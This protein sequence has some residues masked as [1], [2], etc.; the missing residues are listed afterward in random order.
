MRCHYG[1][2]QS[3]PQIISRQKVIRIMSTLEEKQEER[4]DAHEELIRLLGLVTYNFAGLEFTIQ[5]F[6]AQL[7]TKGRLREMKSR[8]D[9]MEGSFQTEL[10]FLITA[11][12][13]FQRKLTMLE[14]LYKHIEQDNKA[15]AILTKLISQASKAAERR[16]TMIH[17]AWATRLG[18]LHPLSIK[19]TAKRDKSKQKPSNLNIDL[20]HT[21]LEE[22]AQVAELI[23]ETQQELQLL[24]MR[25]GR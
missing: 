9:V 16:N 25:R 12:L 2:G 15:V 18:D 23:E 6:I 13:S 8:P 21:K 11:E 4:M 10:A 24:L 14:S 17:S 7:M 19:P 5:L 22:L 3:Y 1:I 20:K